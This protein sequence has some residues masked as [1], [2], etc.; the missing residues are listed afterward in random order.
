MEKNHRQ[1]T[2]GNKWSEAVLKGSS[3]SQVVG[4]VRHVAGGGSGDLNETQD[5]VNVQFK[6]AVSNSTCL[7]G[8][9][10]WAPQ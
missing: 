3:S 9:I 4:T 10:L 2:T 1:Q 6:G 7:I 5:L 8:F